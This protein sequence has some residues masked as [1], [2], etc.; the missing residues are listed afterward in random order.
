VNINKSLISSYISA[1]FAIIIGLLVFGMVAPSFMT[2]E[3]ALKLGLEPS[4]VNPK[5]V[6]AGI[7]CTPVILCIQQRYRWLKKLGW[8]TLWLL[9]TIS[10]I[11]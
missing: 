4:P 6:W 5:F 11:R 10:I 3:Q 9:F 2:N 8:V 1:F 7:V